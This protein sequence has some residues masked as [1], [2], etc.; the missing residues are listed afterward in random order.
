MF[1]G[2]G[3]GIYFFFILDLCMFCFLILCCFLRF[4]LKVGVIVV[5]LFDVYVLWLFCI[6]NVNYK[7]CFKLI[8][9]YEGL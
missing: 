4:R 3:G 5:C 8:F 6:Y 2:G 7:L 9:K 1:K